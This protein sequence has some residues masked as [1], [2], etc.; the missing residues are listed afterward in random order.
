MKTTTSSSPT[1]LALVATLAAALRR[2]GADTKAAAA[3]AVRGA[4]LTPA[5]PATR[6]VLAERDRQDTVRAARDERDRLACRATPA[7]SCR[8]AADLRTQANRLSCKKARE[9]VGASRCREIHVRWVTGPDKCTWTV[10]DCESRDRYSR[11]WHNSYG[12]ARWQEATLKLDADAWRHPDSPVGQT[13]GGLLTLGWEDQPGPWGCRAGRAAW[14]VPGRGASACYVAH[15]VVLLSEYGPIHAPDWDEASALLAAR[16]ERAAKAAAAEAERS[17]RAA[18]LAALPEAERS[19][20][21]TKQAAR[22]AAAA[23]LAQAKLRDQGAALAAMAGYPGPVDGELAGQLGWLANRLQV[24]VTVQDS[25]KAGNCADG[26]RAWAARAGLPQTGATVQ[27][28]VV[29]A[30]HT[31]EELER[32]LAACEAACR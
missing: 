21:A 19:A 14:F 9:A 27:Q 30:L 8:S 23:E 10:T 5:A 17:A 26:T 28:V 11:S 22:R 20:R 12:P 24:M 3:A 32:A 15:G 2:E 25:R 31:G 13:L 1:R 29:A 16:R 4:G 18:R 7:A 6:D